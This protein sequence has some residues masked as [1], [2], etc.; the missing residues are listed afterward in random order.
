MRTTVTE[1]L[2]MDSAPAHRRATVLGGYY[3]LTQELGGIAMPLL[4][5][6]AGAVGIAAAFSGATLGLA[7]LSGVVLLAQRKL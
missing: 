7:V 4:G 3:M 1:V 5:L 6:L 2:V